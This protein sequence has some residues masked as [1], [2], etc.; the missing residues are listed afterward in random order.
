MIVLFFGGAVALLFFVWPVGLVFTAILGV[1]CYLFLCIN[2]YMQQLV[3]AQNG[4]T[5]VEFKAVPQA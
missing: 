3:D 5:N 4:A 1:D 2:S